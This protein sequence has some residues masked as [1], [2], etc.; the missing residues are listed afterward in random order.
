MLCLFAFALAASFKNALSHWTL[1]GLGR[2]DF[3]IFVMVVAWLGVIAL[4]L[5][6]FLNIINKLKQITPLVFV[7][8]SLLCCFLLSTSSPVPMPE[9]IQDAWIELVDC[10][11]II[12]S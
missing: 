6:Y 10:F 3:F 5:V 8:V 4:F 9:K 12:P 11:W 2:A 1:Y 7:A